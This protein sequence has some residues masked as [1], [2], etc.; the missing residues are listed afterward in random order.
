MAHQNRL[1]NA[2][3]LVFGGTSGMGFA[4]ANLCVSQGALVT[5]SGSNQPKLDKKLDQLRSY[6]PDLP[7]DHINGVTC[8]LLDKDNMETNLKDLLEKVTEGGKNK[9]NHIVFC[10]GDALSIPKLAEIQPD[11]IFS[12]FTVRFIAPLLLAKLI[13]GGKY[14]ALETASSMTLTGGTNTYRPFPGWTI[15]A[16][17]GG[18]TDAAVK[19][20]AIE[21]APLRVNQVIPGAIQTELLQGMLDMMGE[22]GSKKFAGDNSLTNTFGQP[23]DIAESYAYL[24][25]DRFATGSFVTCDGGRLLVSQSI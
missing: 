18:A 20:L 17:V 13:A 25:R 4:V 22:E 14:M 16:A 6:Y 11:N 12:A 3:V 9:I 2:N 24:M 23:E 15:P 1:S 5:I 7:K 19:S 10:A 21:L 8:D